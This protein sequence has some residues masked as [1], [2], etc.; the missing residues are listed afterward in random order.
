MQYSPASSQSPDNINS[1]LAALFNIH[2]V[3]YALKIAYRDSRRSPSVNSENRRFVYPHV[4]RSRLVSGFQCSYFA[5]PY[6]AHSVLQPSIAS[7]RDIESKPYASEFFRYLSISCLRVS[8]SSFVP[9]SC[10]SRAS[11]ASSG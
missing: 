2:F 11:K 4:E 9:I 10:A 5:E 3:S 6:S 1:N 7:V 8:L